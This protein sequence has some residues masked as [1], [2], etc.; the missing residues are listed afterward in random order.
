[1]TGSRSA[2][3]SPLCLRHQEPHTLADVAACLDD[4]MRENDVVPM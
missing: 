3:D 2:P 1:M 4:A